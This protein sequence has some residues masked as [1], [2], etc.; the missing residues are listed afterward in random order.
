MTYEFRDLEDL[1]SWSSKV[2]FLSLCQ[3]LLRTPHGPIT[4][5]RGVMEPWNARE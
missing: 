2:L 5:H 3:N 1:T 4:L